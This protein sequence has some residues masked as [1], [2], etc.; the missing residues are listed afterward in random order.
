MLQEGNGVIE[1]LFSV[2]DLFYQP[3]ELKWC[4]PSW[5]AQ[6]IAF[7]RGKAYA[8]TACLLTLTRK[9]KCFLS[10]EQIIVDSNK[11]FGGE[12]CLLIILSLIQS[13]LQ[14]AKLCWHIDETWTNLIY[15]NTRKKLELLSAIGSSDFYGFLMLSNLPHVPWLNGARWA[16]YH[17]LMM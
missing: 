9:S 7:K 11:I 12:N 16:V 4:H 6:L 17:L 8:R 10:Y 2:W 15:A 5:D 13:C 14:K 1:C 3:F